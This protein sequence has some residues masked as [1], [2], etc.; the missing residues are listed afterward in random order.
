MVEKEKV[1]KNCK[2]FVKGDKCP[3]CQGTDF[4]KTW[5]GVVYVSDPDSEIA[6]LLGFKV[7]GKYCIWVKTKPV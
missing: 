5:K 7:P 2:I 1:C 3:I 4:S 6:K